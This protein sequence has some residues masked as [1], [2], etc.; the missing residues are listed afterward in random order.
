MAT[1]NLAGWAVT[2]NAAAEV[3][4]FGPLCEGNRGTHPTGRR[5]A[6]ALTR[7]PSLPG[8]RH[9]GG[10]KSRRAPRRAGC[11]IATGVT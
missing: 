8:W 6:G 10:A 7:R 2:V 9:F 3:Y 5:P 1:S 4:Q 11:V